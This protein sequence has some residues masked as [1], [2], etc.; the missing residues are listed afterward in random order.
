MYRYR[1]FSTHIRAGSF[2]S[3][4]NKVICKMAERDYT[5]L[6]I[7]LIFNSILKNTQLIQGCPVLL[8]VIQVFMTD[9][10]TVCW[11]QA[12]RWAPHSFIVKAMWGNNTAENSWKAWKSV[13]HIY[14]WDHAP[15]S[16]CLKDV[17]VIDLPQCG[18][19]FLPTKH[20]R[21]VSGA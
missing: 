20:N 18:K 7:S 1:L 9:K 12:D 16:Y 6:I 14:R 8:L 19:A 3:G 10:V 17:Q 4:Q 13:K 15:H 21:P 11:H 2:T 5:Y